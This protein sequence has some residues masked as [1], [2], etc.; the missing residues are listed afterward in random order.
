[1][2]YQS[3]HLRLKPLLDWAQTLDI[4][5]NPDP[6]AIYEAGSAGFHIHATPDDHPNCDLWRHSAAKM[7]AGAFSKKCAFVGDARW[8]W[9]YEDLRFTGQPLDPA[10]PALPPDEKIVTIVLSTC[11]Y[12]LEDTRLLDGHKIHN[13]PEDIAWCREKIAHLWRLAEYIDP[14]PPIMTV[15]EWKRYEG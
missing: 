7:I 13:R 8:G 11:A 12:H 14:L 9:A 2:S 1:M 6:H 4:A 10:A 3:E 15:E 5:K